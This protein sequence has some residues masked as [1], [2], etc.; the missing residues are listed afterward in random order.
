VWI[1]WE[2]R[3]YKRSLATTDE[4]E[5]LKKL[6]ALQ[7]TFWLEP[8]R[9][10]KLAEF[11]AKP[12]VSGGG[13]KK[14]DFWRK[15]FEITDRLT[16]RTFNSYE[17]VCEYLLDKEEISVSENYIREL[18]NGRSRQHKPSKPGSVKAKLEGRFF[19]SKTPRPKDD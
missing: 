15:N 6:E 13:E 10:Q 9:K 14:R 16:S 11:R 7:E 5:A 8:E 4:N 12:I 19:V 1:P 2:K 17:K 3:Y 18:V